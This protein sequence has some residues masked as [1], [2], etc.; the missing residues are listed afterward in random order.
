[1]CTLQVSSKQRGKSNKGKKK[2]GQVNTAQR[3]LTR[4][5][6]DAPPFVLPFTA[7]VNSPLLATSD[8][9]R[10]ARSLRLICSLWPA[11]VFNGAHPAKK[12]QLMN[13]GK[14]GRIALPV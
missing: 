6:A 12:T 8:D 4:V 3:E 5:Q 1:M 2:K 10:H 9:G 7:P 13:K 14:V 11:Q